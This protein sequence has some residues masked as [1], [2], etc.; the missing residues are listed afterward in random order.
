M[1]NTNKMIVFYDTQ[2]KV[3]DNEYANKV[4]IEF[5]KQTGWK[6]T[7]GTPIWNNLRNFSK[8]YSNIQRNVT[9]V[10]MIFRIAENLINV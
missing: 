10:V 2:N 7:E 8:G 3:I 9:E 1:T 4:I 6:V 5:R